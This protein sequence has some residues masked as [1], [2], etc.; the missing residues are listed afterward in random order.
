[1]AT[2][3]SSINTLH[4]ALRAAERS[5]LRHLE[6]ALAA[7]R[8]TPDQWSMLSNLSADTGITMSE[9]ASRAQLAPSSATRHADCLA[10]RGLI[11]R[12][13]AADD[14]R[15]I[16]IGLSRRGIDLVGEVRA[17]EQ[18]AEAELRRRLGGTDY[19]EL[20]RLL[21]QVTETPLPD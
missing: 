9:L 8:L 13:A 12:I 16:L 3:V 7:R 5:W 11:F 14:R 21:E 19:Q 15:R 1:M 2:I 20:L 17:E 18:R 10:E 4:G 6:E